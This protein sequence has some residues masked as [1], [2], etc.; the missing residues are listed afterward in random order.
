MTKR[1][2]L[3]GGPGIGK[4]TLINILGEM[5]Y[6]VTF[7]VAR[8]II[9]EQQEIGGTLLPWINPKGFQEAVTLRQLEV[10]SN[11][12]PSGA[13]L[14]FQD[15]SLIDGFGYCCHFGS[16]PHPLIEEHARGWYTKVFLLDPLP[17]YVQD[18]ARQ[19]DRAEAEAIHAAIAKAYIHFGYEPIMV[20]VLPPNER[21][22]FILERV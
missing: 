5:G 3:T 15:R 21:V 13:T 19:E 18:E 20:P 22:K 6:P 4:T 1:H 14:V 17:D 9:D 7:E 16:T 11:L 2:I 8:I 12:L 10:E